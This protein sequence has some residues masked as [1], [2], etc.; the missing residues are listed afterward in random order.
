MVN[1][2]CGSF[3]LSPVINM[4]FW[5]TRHSHCY[6]TATTVI[7]IFRLI[8]SNCFIWG[9]VNSFLHYH[10]EMFQWLYLMSHTIQDCMYTRCF[11]ARSCSREETSSFWFKIIIFIFKSDISDKSSGS[12]N[13]KS[14]VS[15]SDNFF[16][17]MMNCFNYFIVYFLKSHKKSNKQLAYE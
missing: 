13:K 12:S 2:T 1:H 6:F 4:F 10:Q 8:F 16:F 7:A 11:V 5:I 3:F 9:F 15:S 17:G 14:T